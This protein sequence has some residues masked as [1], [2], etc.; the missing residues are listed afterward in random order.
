WLLVALACTPSLLSATADGR[1]DELGLI[2]HGGT[3]LFASV[4]LVGTV[5]HQRFRQASVADYPG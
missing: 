5:A 3:A 2:V 1:T 4:A